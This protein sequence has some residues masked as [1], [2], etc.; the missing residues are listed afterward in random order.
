MLKR[1]ITYSRTVQTIRKKVVGAMIYPSILMS[2][3]VVLVGILVYYVVPTFSEFFMGLSGGKADLPLLTRGLVFFSNFV[4]S[5][6]LII[7]VGAV[8]GMALFQIWR[9]T[10]R[11]RIA[12]DAFKLKIPLVGTVLKSYA[13]SRFARTLSTLVAGG[14]RS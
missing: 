2:L 9:K 4:R 6:I 12:F 5:Y 13:V 14:S 11:G 8:G 3:S 10:A 1:F 7:L